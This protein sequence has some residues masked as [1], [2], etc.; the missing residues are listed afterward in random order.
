MA[1]LFDV[2]ETLRR[3]SNLF[4]G[5]FRSSVRLGGGA[6]LAGMI[7]GNDTGTGSVVGSGRSGSS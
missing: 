4:G 1:V 6:Y 2:T 5:K 3:N 7:G